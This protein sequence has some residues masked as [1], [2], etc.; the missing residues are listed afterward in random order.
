[1]KS[2]TYS[3]NW[4]YDFF[5]LVELAKIDTGV[6]IG[7]EVPITPPD[8]T[9]E[10]IDQTQKKAPADGGP[11]LRVGNEYTPADNNPIQTGARS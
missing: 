8:I 11:P 2:R 3:Y 5:S 7:G 4:P 6:Q 10:P 9:V 1:M